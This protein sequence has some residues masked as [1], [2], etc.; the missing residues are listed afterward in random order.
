MK[1]DVRIDGK[2]ID[3]F[4][5]LPEANACADR[6]NGVLSLTSPEKKAIVVCDYGRPGD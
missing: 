2:T 3:K 5:T 1:Y 4:N 6:L